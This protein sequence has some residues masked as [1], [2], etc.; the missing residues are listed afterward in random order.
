MHSSSSTKLV[1]GTGLALLLTGGLPLAGCGVE[2]GID[3]LKSPPSVEIRSPAPGSA[4]R[5]GAE[6]VLFEGVLTDAYDSPEDLL[7]SWWLD[8]GEPVDLSAD[9]DGVVTWTLDPDTVDLG[10]YNITLQGIDTDE[11]IG[12]ASTYIKVLAPL[13]APVVDITDPGDGDAFDEGEAITFQGEATDEGTDP[14]DLSFAW[15]SS[16]DGVID[17]AVSGDG[18]SIVVAEGLSVGTHTVTLTVTDPDD[19]VG[20]DAIT[21]TVGTGEIEEPTDEA[22]AG[23]LVFSEMMVNPEIVDDEQ[24]EWVELYNTS[25]QAIDVTGYTFRDDDVDA[26]ILEGPLVVQPGD[27]MV[28]CANTNP[29]QNGGVTCDGWF[30]R[31]YQGAGLALA[32]RADELVLARPDGLE[33]DWLQYGDDWFTTAVATGVDPDHLEDGANNDGANWC[34]QVTVMTSGG[35]PGTPG[36]ENDP[37]F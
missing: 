35:E 5:Q 28:L 29:S 6:D 37:C 36:I 25:D 19:E 24:G 17:G 32:N 2:S 11:D 15:E 23:D 8:E 31:D 33:I 27:Y 20:L 7:V 14:S 13:T 16:R 10:D 21:I 34:D 4:V 9:A 26:W 1:R 30:F 18:K 22:L 3:R 12:Q